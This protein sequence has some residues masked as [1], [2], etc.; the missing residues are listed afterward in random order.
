MPYKN[1]RKLYEA[2]K[3]YRERERE[4]RKLLLKIQDLS[5]YKTLSKTKQKEVDQAVII[6]MRNFEAQL[7]AAA[8]E[9]VKAYVHRMTEI[10]EQIVNLFVEYYTLA[11]KI[12]KEQFVKSGLKPIIISQGLEVK[13]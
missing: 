7:E 4:K 12:P 8:D 6:S 11:R 1:K 5:E 10:K 3:R 13:P 9:I 2:Q